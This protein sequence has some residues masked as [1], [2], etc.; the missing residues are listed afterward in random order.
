MQGRSATRNL[1]L[2]AARPPSML[3][4]TGTSYTR[5]N[6]LLASECEWELHKVLWYGQ[7][8]SQVYI[9]LHML[10]YR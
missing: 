8:L 1:Q 5:T 2:R 7:L 10:Q 4:P 3:T 9:H 6:A